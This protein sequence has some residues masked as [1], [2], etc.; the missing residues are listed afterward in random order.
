MYITDGSNPIPRIELRQIIGLQD[1]SLNRARLR[2]A[3]FNRIGSG[4]LARSR[5]DR[6]IP[7]RLNPATHGNRPCVSHELRLTNRTRILNPNRGALQAAPSTNNLIIDG[8]NPARTKTNNPETASKTAGSAEAASD[9]TESGAKES[10]KAGSDEASS[11]KTAPSIES[12]MT[13]SE[14]SEPSSST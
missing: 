10:S 12:S 5:Q 4:G 7:G 8:M 2:C 1:R 3:E 14:M 9:E 11:G 13:I 6:I